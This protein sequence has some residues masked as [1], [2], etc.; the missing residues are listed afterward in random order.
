MRASRTTTGQDSSGWEAMAALANFAPRHSA[1]DVYLDYSSVDGAAATG[2]TLA[3]SEFVNVFGA[4]NGTTLDFSAITTSNHIVN[5][6]G[7]AAAA[8]SLF[9]AENAAVAALGGPGVAWFSYHGDEY[10]VATNQAETHIHAGDAVARLVDAG[11]A[12]GAHVVGATD[13][14]GVVTFISQNLHLLLNA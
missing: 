3:G 5:E 8:A 1:S 6:D 14:G 2:V 7:V 10:F 13:S 11:H 12:S 9:A 4:T